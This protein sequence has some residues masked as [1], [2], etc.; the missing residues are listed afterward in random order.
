MVGEIGVAAGDGLA[1]GDVLGLEVDAVSGE[2]ELRLGAGGGRAFAQG[3][4][5]CRDFARDAGRKV[6]VVG[7]QDAADV[8][9]VRCAGAQALDCRLLVS[10]GHEEGI[11]EL[12][13]IKGLLGE[14]GNGLFNLNG[15]H[16]VVQGLIRS[17]SQPSKSGVLRVATE[18]PRVWAIEAIWQSAWAIGRPADRRA[19][20]MAA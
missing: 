9:L 2:D 7:L 4:E 1:G 14:F 20:E 5:G 16:A 15:V 19:A 17:I 11:G 3:G 12:C 6:D 8:G 18:A 13:R 10:E